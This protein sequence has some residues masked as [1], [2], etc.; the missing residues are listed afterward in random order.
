MK[1][2]TPKLQGARSVQLLQQT[3]ASLHFS[4]TLCPATPDVISLSRK[5]RAQEEF[6]Q[7]RMSII[8]TAK[9]KRGSAIEKLTRVL[10]AVT[11]QVKQGQ[12]QGMQKL[13]ASGRSTAELCSPEFIIWRADCDQLH[14]P[15]EHSPMKRVLSHSTQAIPAPN[16]S[17]SEAHKKTNGLSHQK[18]TK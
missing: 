9:G 12:A 11:S 13:S 17:Q 15:G 2:P 16:G 1:A 5:S 6:N 18:H 14:A 7:A 10:P 4:Q 3:A 8:N